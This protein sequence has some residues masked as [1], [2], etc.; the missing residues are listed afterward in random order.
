[1]ASG[2]RDSR[3]RRVLNDESR[4]GSTLGI[5]RDGDDDES[6]TPPRYGER[7][8][9]HHHPLVSDLVPRRKRSVLALAVCLLGVAAG[10][11]ALLQIRP[12]A[13]TGLPGVAT[14]DLHAVGHG[15]ILWTTALTG[16]VGFLLC[17]F[18]YSLRRH[19]VDDRRGSYRVW[20]VAAWACV[21]WPLCA[22]TQLHAVGGRAA[23]AATGWQLTAGA[24]EWWLAPAMLVS[25]WIGYRLLGEMKESQGA[26]ALL[27]IALACYSFAAVASGGWI[28]AVWEPWSSSMVRTLPL[29]G[30]VIALTGLTGFARYVVLDV[31]G[32]VDHAPA[33]ERRR[34]QKKATPA[35]ASRS[36]K[37]PESKPQQD[38]QADNQAAQR[39]DS[40]SSNRSSDKQ[41]D[42]DA[43][44]D[45]DSLAGQLKWA[46]S[47]NDSD[48]RDDQP[49]KLSK[50]E[51]KRLRN[52]N[53]NRRAA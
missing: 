14:A 42:D 46:H 23:A 1:M 16:L 5:V 51:R 30:H 3:R 50:A 7:A 49:R 17:R 13:P 2:T 34:R 27:L 4:L 24:T 20:R 26:A 53:Q 8:L 31:Q 15:L 19:R 11:E 25:A 44:A 37:S 28:L 32:L 12:D 10:A 9:V 35:K 52:Q 6:S 22:A 48:R 29:V 36:A 40:R 43:A 38:D 39:N 41:R 18:I 45:A 33:V 21:V 47:G